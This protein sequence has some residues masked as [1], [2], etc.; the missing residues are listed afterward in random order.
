MDIFSLLLA[1]SSLA[2]NFRPTED[3]S[4][5]C[6]LPPHLDILDRLGPV[7]AE[8]GPKSRSSEGG[9]KGSLGCGSYELLPITHSR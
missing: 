4:R 6:L 1:S 9:R 8:A 7:L 5:T 2:H 3:I